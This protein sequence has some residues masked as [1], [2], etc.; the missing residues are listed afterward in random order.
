MLP[1]ADV[2]FNYEMLPTEK[3]ASARAAAERIIAHKRLIGESA[4]SIGKDLTEQKAALGHGNYLSWIKS[5][6]SISYDL[7]ARLVRIYEGIGDKVCNL[8]TLSIS[9]LDS[10]ASSGEP[11]RA[12]VLARAADGEKVTAKEIDALKKRLAKTEELAAEKES[13]RLAQ[14]SRANI[15]AKQASDAAN[16]AMFA[17]AS[18]ERLEERIAD[19]EEEISRLREPGVIT[20]DPVQQFNAAFVATT[21]NE[22]PWTDE[23]AQALLVQYAWEKACASARDKFLA[24]AGLTRLKV[25][26]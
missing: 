10:L 22:T 25:M 23:D 18:R 6:C 26:A 17:E 12:E 1:S 8:Q 5:E 11:V 19:M 13:Q 21:P 14:E 9:A 3:A 15:A 2:K 16:R 7:A 4:V 24:S 20:V